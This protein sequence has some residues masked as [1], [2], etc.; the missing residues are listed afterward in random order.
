M[1]IYTIDQLNHFR[2]PLS[3]A[4]KDKKHLK[5]MIKT[6]N[7]GKKKG[8]EAFRV[9]LHND[10]YVVWTKGDDLEEELADGRKVPLD[11]SCYSNHR[12]MYHK[13]EHRLRKDWE[14]DQDLID[15][16]EHRARYHN[17]DEKDFIELIS[18][19]EHREDR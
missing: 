16:A 18:A 8:E 1:K 4:F 7:A 19:A 11:P 15:Q 9:C 3:D 5:D 14:K 10:N 17:E 2:Y 13:S 6:L 12:E